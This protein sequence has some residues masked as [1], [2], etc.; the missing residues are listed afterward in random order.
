[1]DIKDK[2]YLYSYLANGLIL[3]GKL[4]NKRDLKWY[5]DELNK[6]NIS[7]YLISDTIGR[8]IK[9]LVVKVDVYNYILLL[10]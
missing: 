9:K 3:K 10:K 6:R 2:D 1:M 7:I 8:K 4:L 5:A